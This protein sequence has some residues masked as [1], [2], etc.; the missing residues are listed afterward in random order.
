[1][2][3]GNDKPDGCRSSTPYTLWFWFVPIHSLTEGEFNICH[4]RQQVSTAT[5]TWARICWQNVHMFHHFS[6]WIKLLQCR[7]ND[8]LSTMP[9]PR[10]L[11]LQHAH[12]FAASGAPLESREPPKHIP[13][14][15]LNM[16]IV[17]Q[18]NPSDDCFTFTNL[19]RHSYKY[20]LA[21]VPWPHYRLFHDTQQPLKHD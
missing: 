7:D 11:H 17:Y 19:L 20:Q 3:L 4:N 15:K 18:S 16:Y 21:K 13:Q 14:T 10:Y 2:L 5:P 1:M 9:R 6:Q 12:N 8:Q